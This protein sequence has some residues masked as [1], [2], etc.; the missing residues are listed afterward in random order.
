MLRLL[1]FGM[2]GQLSLP[3]LAKLLSAGVEIAAVIIPEDTPPDFS[4]LGERKTALAVSDW[5]RPVEPPP[6]APTDL[7]LLN[8]YLTPNLIHLAWARHVP[9]WQV[10][11]L[12]DSATLARL[13]SFQADLAVVA[14]FPYLFPASLRQLFRYGCLN[15]HPSLLPAYRGP[16]P[17]FWQARQGEAQAGVTWHY[18]DEGLDSGDMVSQAAF[19][20]PE[21]ISLAQLERE[22]ANLGAQ[23]LLEAVTQLS[24]SGQLPR[25]PQPTAGASYFSFPGEADRVIPTTWPARRAFNFIRLAAVDW[26]LVI[27]AADEA[28]FLIREA[29]AYTA[30]GVLGQPYVQQDELVWIQFNSGVLQVRLR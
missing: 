28:R 6:P 19:E 26:P 22:C 14:C 9:V 10:N 21:G 2:T 29:M 23:L 17:L 13:A 30:E 16:T 11:S 25:R 5:P 3:P 8:P 7:P 12:A 20:W 4:T 1:F 27:A 15:L 24:Q 18:L